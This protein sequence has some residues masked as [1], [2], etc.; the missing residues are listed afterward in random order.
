MRKI[1]YFVVIGLVLYACEPKGQS[2]N[3][4]VIIIEGEYYS[5]RSA[6]GKLYYIEKVTLHTPPK[7]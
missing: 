7:D 3:D 2:L 4:K 5:I 6:G 1:L